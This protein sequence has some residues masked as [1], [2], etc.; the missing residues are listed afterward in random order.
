[1]PMP[2]A[3]H[4]ANCTPCSFQQLNEL[5]EMFTHIL[6]IR[7]QGLINKF[8]AQSYFAGKDRDVI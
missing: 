5:G 1:M 8:L 4:S 2:R 6:Q 7:K 3:R